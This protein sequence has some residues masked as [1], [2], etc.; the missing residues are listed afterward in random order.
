MFDFTQTPIW[1]NIA[2][3]VA[4]AVVVWFAGARI[5]GYANA[6]SNK[7]GIGQAAIGML[8][9]GGVTSLPEIGA[10]VTGAAT[11][12]ALLAVNNLFGSIAAQVVILAIVD[13]VIGRRALTSELPDPTVMLQ[14]GLNILLIT[15]ATAGI[16]VG[17]IAFLGIGLWAWASIFAYAFSIYILSRAG[18]GR[19][20]LAASHGDVEIGLED[21]HKQAKEKAAQEHADMSLGQIIAWT[22]GLGLVILVSGYLLARTGDALAEQTGLGDSAVGFVFLAFATSLPE[23]ST[24]ITAA[25]SGLYTL[26]VSDIFGTNLINIGLIFVIDAVAPGEPVLAQAGTFDAFGALLGI[27]VTVLFV[28]GM[29]ERRD[30]TVLRMGLDSLAVLFCYA[31]GLVVLFFLR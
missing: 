26:A 31:A 25:K 22:V 14:G 16:T 11:G 30:K 7:T 5:T 6:I 29:A 18:G 21:Q 23:F 1:I 27:A 9:L 24:A 4:A 17:D 20:W 28:I 12:A 8:L 3:F 13:I 10:T 2:V 19:P 15:I